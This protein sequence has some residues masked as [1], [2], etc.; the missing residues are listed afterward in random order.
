M[1]NHLLTKSA[2][3][4]AVV[5]GILPIITGAKVL[6]GAY[7]PN[8]TVLTWLV[9]YNITAGFLSVITGILIWKPKNI[10][11]PLTSV[12]A[13]AHIIILSLLLT[14]F[15]STVSTNSI[16]AMVFRSVVWIVIFI[17]VSKNNKSTDA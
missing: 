8:Y 13:A 11:L 7:T 17:I 12:I 16:K 4:I 9:I 10:S 1:K 14:V 15:S 3:V 6:T 5:I 2:S